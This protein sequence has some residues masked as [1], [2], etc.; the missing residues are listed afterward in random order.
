MC[1]VL[2]WKWNVANK[3]HILNSTLKQ[4]IFHIEYG[5]HTIFQVNTWHYYMI[6]ATVDGWLRNGSDISF[7][8]LYS[9]HPTRN[10][11]A[12]LKVKGPD[13]SGKIERHIRQ[14]RDDI[15]PP[16]IGKVHK[17][18]IISH[19]QWNLTV[20]SALQWKLYMFFEGYVSVKTGNMIIIWYNWDVCNT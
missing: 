17:C 5:A 8:C 20:W 14:T 18:S 2:S 16:R 9:I 12:M 7:A 13:K 4:K 11:C 1:S 19:Q 15:S 3:Y 10:P 6:T